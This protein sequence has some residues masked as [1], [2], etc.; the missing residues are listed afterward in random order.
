MPTSIYLCT[1]SKNTSTSRKAVSL[2][3]S[4]NHESAIFILK[5]GTI[6]VHVTPALLICL[7][8]P[9]SWSITEHA[10]HSRAKED[11]R[12]V[13]IYSQTYLFSYNFGVRIKCGSIQRQTN[14]FFRLFSCSIS[15]VTPFERTKAET[16]TKCFALYFNINLNQFMI[17]FVYKSSFFI[18]LLSSHALLAS[19]FNLF[20]L[21]QMAHIQFC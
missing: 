20:Q 10:N 14:F 18:C 11:E 21:H 6:E 16:K 5:P 3:L 7:I 2:F 8:Q 9:T 12:N 15:H 13:I 17:C 19:T 4:K 1:F